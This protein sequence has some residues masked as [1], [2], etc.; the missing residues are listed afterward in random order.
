MKAEEIKK[1]SVKQYLNKI[2]QHLYDLINDH[3][4]ARRV[5]KIQIS[6]RVNFI[7]SKDTGE[8]RTIYV[9]SDNVSIMR[10]SDTDDIIRELF[11]SFLHNYQEELKIIKGSDFVFESVELMDYKLHRVRLRRS[12]SYIKSFEWLLHKGA[13]IN[14]KNENDYECLRWSI[15]STLNYNEITKKKFENIFKKIKHEDKDFSLHQRDWKNFE[16]NNN[17]IA[18]NV[19]FASQNSKEIT[20]ASKSEHNF[21]RKNNVLLLMINDDDDDDDDKYYYFTVK[22]KLE[23]YSSEWLRSKKESITN[24]DS[25]FQNALNDALDYQRIKR[26]PQ[27]I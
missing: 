16:Q 7:S 13:T 21:K 6:M 14:P 15:T 22:N 24:G 19:L 17:S 2:T 12:G 9:W 4:I 3:R 11:R 20:L 8:T 5:W 26:D 10:G 1:L 18:L 23:L 27:Q 25:C